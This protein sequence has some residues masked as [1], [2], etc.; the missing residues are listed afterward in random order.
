VCPRANEV[1]RHKL[2]PPRRA[3][4]GCA[5]VS[6]Y[7]RP[8]VWL[9][10]LAL[11]VTSVVL[12]PVRMLDAQGLPRYRALKEELRH[13]ERDNERLAREVT[14]LS[15]EVEA[16]RSDP[17]AVE[18]IARDELGMVRPHEVVFQFPE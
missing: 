12:V 7:L 2:D 11:L 16:L 1:G 18:R 6:A 15:R 4:A 5:T 9:L 10:P 14:E 3:T 13:V 17:A 8:L